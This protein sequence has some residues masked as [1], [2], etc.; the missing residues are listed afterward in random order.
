MFSPVWLSKGHCGLTM[1]NQPTVQRNTGY[2][3]QCTA[4][5]ATRKFMQVVNCSGIVDF[6]W[7]QLRVSG[8]DQSLLKR[9]CP[10]CCANALRIT[11]EFPRKVEPE[12]IRV[13]H[14]VGVGAGD[15]MPL[16]WETSP[17]ADLVER[18]FDFKYVNG[19]SHYG[20]NKAAVFGE[21]DLAELFRLYRTKAGR[22]GFLCP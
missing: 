17:N 14:I 15:Y 19:R 4:C 21:Q 10:S 9:E 12:L 6:L 20:L 18:W 13:L 2:W 11:Y 1:S 16:M 7:D 8:W 5:N 3:W 22:P